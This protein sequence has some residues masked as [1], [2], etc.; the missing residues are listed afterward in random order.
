MSSRLLAPVGCGFLQ[1]FRN[2]YILDH[3]KQTKKK[4]HIQWILVG[5]L[6]GLY[7]I[8]LKRV[9]NMYPRYMY[10]GLWVSFVFRLSPQL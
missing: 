4:M 7:D 9:R 3:E 1:H 8:Y 5:L 6:C 2:I 10:T